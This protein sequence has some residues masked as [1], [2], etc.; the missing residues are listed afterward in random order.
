MAITGMDEAFPEVHSP[1][2][3][4]IRL[5]RQPAVPSSN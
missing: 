4:A 2:L 5:P 3:A 1:S